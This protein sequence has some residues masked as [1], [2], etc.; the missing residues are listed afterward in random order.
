MS[1]DTPSSSRRF[2]C[3]DR[4]RPPDTV[5]ISKKSK[6]QRSRRMEPDTEFSRQFRA[7]RSWPVTDALVTSISRS[8]NCPARDRGFQGQVLFRGTEPE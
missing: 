5:S 7:V 3:P 8:V 1:A 6:L 2:A 4:V